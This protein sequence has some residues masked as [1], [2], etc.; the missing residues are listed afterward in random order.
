MLDK[1]S[2]TIL[3]LILSYSVASAQKQTLKQIGEID[4]LYSKVLKTNREIY[5]QYPINYNPESKQRYPLLLVLDGEYILSLVSTVQDYYSGGFIPDM[6]VVGVSNAKNRIRD[7]TPSTITEKYG[8]PFNA[9]SG[10][11]DDFL[12]FIQKELIP[13]LEEK[14]PI[15]NYRTLIGHSYAGLFTTY[16]FLKEPALFANYLAID[17]SLDWDDQL[18]LKEAQLP[19]KNK[20][21][22]NK[23]LFMSM[24]GHLHMQ[25][26]SITIDNVMEDSSDYTIFPRSILAFKDLASEHQENGLDFY[27]KFYPNDLHGTVVF[28]SVYEGLIRIFEWYQMENTAKINSFDTPLEE[29]K[30]VIEFR[31]DKL[32]KHFG[33]AEPPYPEELMNMLGYMNLEMKQIEKAKIVFEFAIQYFPE[34]VNAY[35]AMADFYISQKDRENAILYLQKAFELS[36]DENYI[37]RIRELKDK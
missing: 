33:Y 12:K 28:P 20:N 7:L 14:Y 29:L 25:D 11:A 9:E 5:I 31:A 32:K 35:D 15:T 27:W 16:T 19:L 23:A 22:E 37:K 26:A 17:P 8:M 24:S 13:Y 36:G 2:C 18:L 6:I 21:Y 30:A 10:G 4:S 34:S 1:I 3:I